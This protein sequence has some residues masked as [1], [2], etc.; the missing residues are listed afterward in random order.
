MRGNRGPEE[1][2]KLATVRAEIISRIVLITTRPP[3]ATSVAG[4]G[5]LGACIN[6]LGG[7][8]PWPHR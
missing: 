5:E 3:A 6:Y 1:S 8:A 7:V 2:I 4:V